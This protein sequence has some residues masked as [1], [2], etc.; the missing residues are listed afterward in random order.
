MIAQPELDFTAA[1]ALR[2]EGISRAAARQESRVLG[3][4]DR[5]VA[6]FDNFREPTFQTCQFARW[7][8]TFGL[9]A[10]PEGRA[11]G[12]VVVRLQKAGRIERDG[13]APCVDPSQHRT[14][15]AVWR[16]LSPLRAALPVAGN[17]AASAAA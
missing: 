11:W 15:V 3:W 13:F 10:A 14:P 17:R 2:D 6:M 12:A 1:V 7:C 9:P 5:A 4:Q 16:K 8:H